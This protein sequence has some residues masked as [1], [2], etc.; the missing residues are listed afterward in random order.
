VDGAALAGLLPDLPRWVELRDVLRGPH[1]RLVASMPAP[2]ALVVVDEESGTVY[3]AGAPPASALQEAITGGAAEVL[4]PPESLMTVTAALPG[5]TVD[6]IDVHTRPDD[7]ALPAV[8][9]GNVRRLD[10]AAVDALAGIPPDLHA[11]L[12]AAAHGGAPITAALVDGVPAAF[13]YAGATSEAWWDVAID[14]LEPYQRQGLA[15]RAFAAH[16]AAERRHGR[17]PVWCAAH[18]N[19]ASGLLA[20]R[21]GFVVVDRLYVVQR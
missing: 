4:C 11:E 19:P 14:T 5:W 8:P 6:P 13:C 20:A 18:T 1:A 17:S 10:R 3:V 12:R 9:S 7:A 16:A 15:A 21:L 2:L